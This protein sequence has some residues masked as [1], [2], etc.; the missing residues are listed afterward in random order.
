MI[1]MRDQGKGGFAVLLLRRHEQ[2]LFMGGNFVYP[3][4]T[5]NDD[6]EREEMMA[7]SRGLT[8]HQ[9]RN[10]LGEKDSKQTSLGYWIAGIRELFEEA[11][12]LI[13]YDSRDRLFGPE[14]TS[15]KEKLTRYRAALQKKTIDFLTFLRA[16][17]LTLALDRCHYYAHWITPEARKVRFD[18]R[19]FVIVD[20]SGQEASPDRQET[21]ESLWLAPAEALQKNLDGSLA[22][23]PPTLKTLEDLARFRSASEVLAALPNIEKPAILPILLNP[24]A[25]EVLIFPWDPDYEDLKSGRLAHPTDHGVVSGPHD[26]TTRLVLKKGRWIPYTKTGP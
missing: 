4:G 25:D 16:E 9:A 3:G 20:E 1:V 26:N 5:V 6:D 22:L 2:N 18:T 24:K 13:A 21:T 23:S 12:L 15:A 8:P 17:S 11:G 14:T 19:F 7:V 10:T